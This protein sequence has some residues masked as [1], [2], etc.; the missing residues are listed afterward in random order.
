MKNNNMNAHNNMNVHNNMNGNN[1]MDANNN[2]NAQ[3]TMNAHN[4]MNN[5]INNAKNYNMNNGNKN[6]QNNQGYSNNNNNDKNYNGNNQV[7]NNQIFS[8]NYINGNK[9]NN[10][11]LKPIS[12]RL[13]NLHDTNYLNAVLYLLGN[14]ENFA[15]YFLDSQ[16]QK[17]I[18]DNIRSYPLSFVIYRLF[19]HFYPEKEGE[20]TYKPDS[21][22][23]ILGSL[24]IVYKSYNKRNPNELIS[25][26][27]NTLHNELNQLKNDK[28]NKNIIINNDIFNKN[29]VIKCEFQKFQNSHNSI[30]SNLLN[31]FEIKES[32]CTECT[33]TM[34]NMHTFNICELDILGC[35]RYK[36]NQNITIMDC[37][38]YSQNTKNQKKYC[39]NCKKLTPMKNSSKIFTPPN[40]FIFSLYRGELNTDLMNVKVHIEENLNLSSYIENNKKPPTQFKLAGIISIQKKD[41]DYISFCMSPY[42]KQ[43][44]CYNNNKINTM[45][46]QS[47]LNAH[48]NNTYIPCILEYIIL[49]KNNK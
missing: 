22:M 29:S 37:L 26:I 41:N 42:D 10:N 44:Y 31:W 47:I 43:W 3:N 21:L 13:E 2:V 34:Y 46:L 8:N 15:N 33:Q 28:N 35:F 19:Y 7:I 27:L 12:I 39:Q 40:I 16:N 32:K 30:V 1:N 14:I 9:N 49:E 23:K 5:N 45:N 48:N 24:N 6:Y 36:K 11:I 38:E 20:K 17:M 4:V 25:F 18:M